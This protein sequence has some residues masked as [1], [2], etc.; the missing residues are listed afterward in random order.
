MKLVQELEQLININEHSIFSLE[1][2]YKYHCYMETLKIMKLKWPVSI[3][4]LLVP[5][6]RDSNLSLRGQRGSENNI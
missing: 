3:C 2:L 4:K 1:N 6:L 5:S